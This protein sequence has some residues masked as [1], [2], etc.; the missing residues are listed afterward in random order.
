MSRLQES[1]FSASASLLNIEQ[2]CI[3]IDS[4]RSAKP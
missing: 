2:E 4:G 1:Y 3:V